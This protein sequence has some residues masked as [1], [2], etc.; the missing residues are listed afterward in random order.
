MPSMFLSFTHPT[1]PVEAEGM[2]LSEEEEVEMTKNKEKGKEEKVENV[3]EE[4]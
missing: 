2:C 3:Y 4:E 1:S